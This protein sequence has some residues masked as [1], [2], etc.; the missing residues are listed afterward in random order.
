MADILLKII[1]REQRKEK[2]ETNCRNILSFLRDHGAPGA[3]M[4]RSDA[5]LDERGRVSY[6]ILEDPY[7]NDLPVVI[8]AVMER[9]VLEE[10]Q[11]GVKQM[12]DHGQISITQGVSD[13]EME[14]HPHFV[15]K[16]YT[17]E[18]TKL[19]KQ[20]EYEK[21]LEIL[22]SHKAI[23]ATVTKAIA[24]YGRDRVIYGQHIFSPGE[25]LPLVIECIAERE[26]LKPLLAEL[27][28]AVTEGAVFTAPVELIQNK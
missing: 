25:H 22:R 21:I 8:E 23:W 24:G 2:K 4:K 18:S 15:V 14:L 12:A 10:M 7:F 27:Q 20:G 26:H 3:T 6:D 16:I 17:K 19:I 5:G 13:E 28:L 11:E 1:V 9:S